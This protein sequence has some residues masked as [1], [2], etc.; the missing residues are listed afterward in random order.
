MLERIQNNLGLKIVSSGLAVLAWLYLR[1]NANPIVAAQFDQRLSVP[2]D[3]V[4]LPA[5]ELARVGEKQVLVTLRVPRSR[6]GSI[7]PGEVRAVIELGGRVPGAYDV[8]VTVVAPKLEITSLSPAYVAV[9]V[10]RI[11]ERRLPVEPH[12]VG[13]NRA[14][15]IVGEATVSPAGVT[16]RAPSNT[17]AQIAGIRVDVPIPSGAEEFDAM[18]RPVAVDAAGSEVRSVTPLPNLVRVRVRFSVKGH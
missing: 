5:D 6:L 7:K 13:A 18:V 17:F 3:V 4:G 15:L 16:L 9:E 2:I 1:F 8:P 14:G 10:D 12:Y 11:E